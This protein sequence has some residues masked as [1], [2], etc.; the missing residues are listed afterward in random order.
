MPETA[1]LIWE[2]PQKMLPKSMVLEE[3]NRTKWPLNLI[4]KHTKPNNKDCSTAKSFQSRPPFW[5][6]TESPN[7][8]QSPKTTAFASK[9]PYKA[10]PNSNPPSA[11]TAPPPP[12]TAP[13]LPMVLLQSSSL[14]VQLPK[15]SAYPS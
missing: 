6:R 1:Y 10:S 5:T 2:K 7:K 11:R 13:N 12:A 8:S 4:P 9:P 3:K 14:V 15:N